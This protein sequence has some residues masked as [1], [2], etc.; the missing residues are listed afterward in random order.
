MHI[1]AMIRTHPQLR[2]NLD[3]ALIR[4]IEACHD[5]AAS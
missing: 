4:C 5:C 3:T 2:G 1:E